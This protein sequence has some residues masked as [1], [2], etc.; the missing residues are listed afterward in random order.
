MVGRINFSLSAATDD[1]GMTEGKRGVGVLVGGTVKAGQYGIRVD[2]GSHVIKSICRYLLPLSHMIIDKCIA[3]HPLTD[4]Y[5]SRYLCG[6]S[7]RV[8]VG[9]GRGEKGRERE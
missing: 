7:G 1:E 4:F 2:R 3:L 6:G 8:Y 9:R 5:C